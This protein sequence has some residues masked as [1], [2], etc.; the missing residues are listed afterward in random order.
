[1]A[2]E[3]I[4]TS[5]DYA[6]KN[7]GWHTEHSAWKAS[8]ALRLLQ[9]HNL[10]P[11]SVCE[12]G[13]GAGEILVQMSQKL[14]AKFHGFEISPQAFALTNGR[15]NSKIEFTLGDLL[16]IQPPVFD[17]VMAMD[18]FEHVEDYLGFL[19]ALR[20]RGKRKLFHIPLDVSCLSVLRPFYLQMARERV[21]HL[22]FFTK[23]SA[24]SS[25]R[26]CGYQIIDA[27]YTAVELDLPFSGVKRGNHLRK[28]IA[29]FN[30]DLASSLLGG[31]SLLVLAE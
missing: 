27:A 9:K 12:V 18:V 6:A 16:T 28:V 1:M 10:Q 22:H 25:L 19:R 2:S 7:P 5:G 20:P 31:F 26:H 4:Y 8:Q 15:S 24:L 11:R 23:E 3:D 21:G 29:Q 17:L 13:C 30:P 14:D